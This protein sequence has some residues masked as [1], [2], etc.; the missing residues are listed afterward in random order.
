MRV[1]SVSPRIVAKRKKE[2]KKEK[3]Y[4]FIIINYIINQYSK[5]YKYILYIYI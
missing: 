3:I 1:S 2:A 4:I 5:Y